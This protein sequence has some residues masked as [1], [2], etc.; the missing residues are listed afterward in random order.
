MWGVGAV[1]LRVLCAVESMRLRH[2][3]VAH[4]AACTHARPHPMLYPIPGVQDNQAIALHPSGLPLTAK[5]LV[6]A[7]LLY[8]DEGA[9]IKAS[10]H[11]M[12]RIVSAGERGMRHVV[13]NA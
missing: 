10:K 4:A 11:R 6:D 12:A 2:R 7:G 3:H 9:S 5:P 8:D 13:D 1:W